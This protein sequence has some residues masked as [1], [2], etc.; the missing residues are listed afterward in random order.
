MGPGHLAR[1]LPERW[2]ALEGRASSRSVPLQL[3]TGHPGD[4]GEGEGVPVAPAL[5]F[6]PRSPAH[7]S[8]SCAAEHHGGTTWWHTA[9]RLVG[10]RKQR[11]TGRGGG[12]TP[13]LGRTPSGHLFQLG[14]E[15]S[16]HACWHHQPGPAAEISGLLEPSHARASLAVLSPAAAEGLVLEHSPSGSSCASERPAGPGRS[17]APRQSHACPS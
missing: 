10:A 16:Q 3:W 13:P 14:P 1:R 6:Q 9:A 17:S 11:A 4:Q 5:R 7:C 15:G 12:K 8:G 2:M